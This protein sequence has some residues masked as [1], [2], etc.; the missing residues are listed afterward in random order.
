MRK[1]HAIFAEF[2]WTIRVVWSSLSMF[3]TSAMCH[4]FESVI[5]AV[6]IRHEA[7]RYHLHFAKNSQFCTFISPSILHLAFCCIP[8]PITRWT[9][10]KNQS[11]TPAALGGKQLN[12]PCTNPCGKK[13]QCVFFLCYSLWYFVLSYSNCYINCH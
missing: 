8:T 2:R 1:V 9:S 11:L 7:C 12:G 5:T 10:K 4:L 6:A 13:G 3:L